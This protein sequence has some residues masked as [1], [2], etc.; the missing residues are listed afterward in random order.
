MFWNPYG[1]VSRVKLS[2]PLNT[3]IYYEYNAWGHRIFQMVIRGGMVTRTWYS[4]DG[5]GNLLSTYKQ[6]DGGSIAVED[7][8]VYGLRKIGTV[9]FRGAQLNSS[10]SAVI[11]SIPL[12]KV[13]YELLNHL[14]SVVALVTDKKVGLDSAGV[15]NHYVAERI[16]KR[17]YY[18]FGSTIT[19]RSGSDNMNYYFGNQGQMISPEMGEFSGIY[20]AEYW[21]YDSRIG[22]RWNIDPV[23]RASQSPYMT[24]NNNPIFFTDPQGLASVPR[25]QQVAKGDNLTRIAADNNVS[26]SD[27]MRWNPSI[28]DK[29][30]IQVGQVLNVS[31]PE[32]DLLIGRVREGLGG[33]G[34]ESSIGGLPRRGE[35]QLPGLSSNPNAN[36]QLSNATLERMHSAV[37]TA[38][39]VLKRGDKEWVKAESNIYERF[40]SRSGGVNRATLGIAQEMAK[41]SV[42]QNYTV[43]LRTAFRQQMIDF[44]GNYSSIRLD[45]VREL[46]NFSGTSTALLAMV[47]GTQQNDIYL[48]DIQIHGRTYT[49]TL[50]FYLFDDYGV[51]EQDVVPT[52]LRR[53]SGASEGLQAQWILQHNRGYRP[54][55]NIFKFT[56]TIVG[57]F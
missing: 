33:E 10:E 17:D 34:S 55:I 53:L 25:Q 48:S 42:F 51:S 20:S 47:G 36:D 9:G 11:D 28:K 49:A 37:S 4:V 26:V 3:E 12:G 6:Y 41:A 22:R 15:V 18:A 13:K 31:D 24:F 45:N 2:D 52:K 30:K 39:T 56:T 40:Y 14:Q 16:L 50:T 44:K 35:L 21:Q 32:Q 8:F 7:F 27:L 1:K 19:I 5:M 57:E 23:T 46:P 54:L 29:N 38:A 43:R